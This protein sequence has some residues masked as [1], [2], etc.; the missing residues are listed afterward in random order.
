MGRRSAGLHLGER[1][2][3]RGA[4]LSNLGAGLL[5]GGRTWFPMDAG[6]LDG[7]GEERRRLRADAAAAIVGERSQQSATFGES[8]LGAGHLG[9]S[10]CE[11]RATVRL[12]DR[13]LDGVPA[14]LDFYSAALGVDAGRVRVCRRVLGLHAVAARLLYSR[15]CI[16]VRRCI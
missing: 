13:I 8:I 3:S 12:A 10:E 9:L 15:R 16:T 4:A 1:R 14:R 5:G 7:R 11:C 2:V 6:V